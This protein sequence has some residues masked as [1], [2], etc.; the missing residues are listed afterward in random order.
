MDD[1]PAYEPT[2]KKPDERPRAPGPSLEHRGYRTP[3]ALCP[4]GWE[5]PRQKQDGSLAAHNAKPRCT[6]WRL[7]HPSRRV[8]DCAARRASPYRCV[9]SRDVTAS[10]SPCPTGAS[11]HLGNGNPS[12]PSL[13]TTTPFPGVRPPMKRPRTLFWSRQNSNVGDLALHGGRVTGT[14]SLC[15]ISK[16]RPRPCVRLFQRCFASFSQASWIAA[17]EYLGLFVIDL[18]PPE[19][20]AQGWPSMR[21]NGIGITS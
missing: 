20:V 13:A 21:P 5:T 14:A 17:D 1:I 15:T 9:C 12:S 11:L 6:T 3:L 10:Y 18:P 8:L 19:S 16:P 4:I 7:R 2:M